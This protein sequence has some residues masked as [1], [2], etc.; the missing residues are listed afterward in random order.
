LAL[1]ACPF[2]CHARKQFILSFLLQYSEIVLS[3]LLSPHEYCVITR[4]HVGG[5]LY[6]LMII[7]TPD[8][9]F[10]EACCYFFI[11]LMELYV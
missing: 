6:Y 10:V 11:K 1:W 2:Y 4:T 9:L 7:D 3:T 8:H 5:L